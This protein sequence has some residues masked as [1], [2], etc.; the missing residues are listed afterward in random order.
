M[1]VEDVYLRQISGVGEVEV[2]RADGLGGLV[3]EVG[4]LV[5]VE[6][7]LACFGGVEGVEAVGVHFGGVEGGADAA[8]E[9]VSGFTV[10]AVI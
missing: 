10:N 6:A 7:E 4:D 3:I 8:V 1:R 2:R 9:L 5:D